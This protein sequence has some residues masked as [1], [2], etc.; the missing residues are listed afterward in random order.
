MITEAPG[1]LTL[2]DQ[3]TQSRLDGATHATLDRGGP[4][5]TGA[6]R[7]HD[8]LITELDQGDTLPVEYVSWLDAVRFCN[9]FRGRARS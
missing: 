2:N 4:G 7:R 5:H 9:A 8:R 3:R 1:E 6:L